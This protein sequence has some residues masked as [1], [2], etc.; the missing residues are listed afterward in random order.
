MPGC[1][2]PTP[3]CA[4]GDQTGLAMPRALNSSTP[5]TRSIPSS[6]PTPFALRLGGISK[7]QVS[8]ESEYDRTIKHYVKLG[9][10]AV[11]KLLYLSLCV[12]WCQQ[13]GVVQGPAEGRDGAG[14]QRHLDGELRGRNVHTVVLTPLLAT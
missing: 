12:H 13:P 7:P 2:C 10:W 5:P 14:W 1:K 11:V 3:Y 4:N 6:T 8:A 9:V